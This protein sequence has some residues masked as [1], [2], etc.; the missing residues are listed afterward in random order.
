MCQRRG[1]R[2]RHRAGSIDGSHAFHVEND[3]A[4]V[5]GQPVDLQR[6]LFGGPEEHRAFELDD[7]DPLAPLTQELGLVREVDPP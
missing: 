3:V 7:F 6:E 2:E 4:R 1:A 5:A